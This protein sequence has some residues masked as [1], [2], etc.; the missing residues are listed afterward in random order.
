MKVD[1]FKR[2]QR[3][4]I[5]HYYEVHGGEGK[6]R[7]GYQVVINFLNP[8]PIIYV[9]HNNPSDLTGTWCQYEVGIPI[10]KEEYMKAYQLAVGNPEV[11]IK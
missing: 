4:N 11:I 5:Y 8:A 10:T 9:E 1:Y 7:D 6:T 2:L 3:D